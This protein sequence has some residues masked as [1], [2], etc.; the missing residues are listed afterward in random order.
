[1]NL[2]C[3]EWQKNSQYGINLV[4][5]WDHDSTRLAKNA[6]NYGIQSYSDINEFLAHPL[7]AVVI[8]AETALHAELVE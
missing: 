6:G 2:Y 1:V 4:A 5:G 3:N 7:Q 8:A